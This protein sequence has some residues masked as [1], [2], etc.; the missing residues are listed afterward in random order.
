M[1]LRYM[2]FAGRCEGD[3]NPF[4]IQPEVRGEIFPLWM[5]DWLFGSGFPS[6]AF[7]IVARETGVDLILVVV[8]SASRLRLVVVDRKL[9]ANICFANSAVTTAKSV[10]LP[11][12]LSRGRRHS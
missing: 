10:Q 1:Q 6:V 3:E 11:K 7:E 9:R 8:R 4:G 2:P 12:P 5:E